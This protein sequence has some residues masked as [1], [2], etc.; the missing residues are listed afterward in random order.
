MRD[1]LS[2]HKREVEDAVNNNELAVEIDQ[3]SLASYVL[4][5]KTLLRIESRIAKATKQRLRSRVLLYYISDRVDELRMIDL[6]QIIDLDATLAA[7]GELLWRFARNW[8]LR[9]DFQQYLAEEGDDL[10]ARG[11][12]LFYLFLLRI[13]QMPDKPALAQLLESKMNFNLNELR[14]ARIAAES[15]VTSPS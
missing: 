13:T 6:H 3:D 8:M 4:N 7:E 14:D 15:E 10:V 9:A 1:Q 11:I 2:A 5:S 12:G